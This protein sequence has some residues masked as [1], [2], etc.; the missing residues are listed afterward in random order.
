MNSSWSTLDAPQIEAAE[1]SCFHHLD[2]LSGCV[3]VEADV[4]PRVNLA[5]N[6]SKTLFS[7][8]VLYAPRL[9]IDLLPL[10]YILSTG[11]V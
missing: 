3:L 2:P 8:V 5:L 11:M 1:R 6:L 7:V 9:L 4:D 10:K